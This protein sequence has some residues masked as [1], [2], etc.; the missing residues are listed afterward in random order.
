MLHTCDII[1]AY[2]NENWGGFGYLGERESH[3]TVAASIM[4][5]GNINLNT[6][7]HALMRVNK[8]DA[9]LIE[10][11]NALG[12]SD[13]LLFEFLNSRNGRHYGDSAFGC[14]TDYDTLRDRAAKDLTY[15]ANEIAMSRW[16]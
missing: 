13:V 7:K 4:A 5:R 14:D 2:D 9:A 6:F 1:N 15:I 8:A 10:A 16:G 12:A 3:L 11:A